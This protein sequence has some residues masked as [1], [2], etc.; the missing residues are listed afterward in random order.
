[1]LDDMSSSPSTVSPHAALGRPSAEWL[2]VRNSDFDW[3]DTAQLTP[4]FQFYKLHHQD[5]P[6]LVGSPEH[7]RSIMQ[8]LKQK[9][10]ALVP[11]INNGLRMEDVEIKSFDQAN[12]KLRI[13]KP[14]ITQDSIQQA[15]CVF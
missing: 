2:E 13:Y 8:E 6:L 10:Q 15:G 5:V 1:M 14:S 4:L 12:I 7:M 11:P 3:H 9:A